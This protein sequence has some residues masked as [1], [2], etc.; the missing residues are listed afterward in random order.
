MNYAD[1]IIKSQFGI[2][3]LQL[4]LCQHSQKPLINNS[5]K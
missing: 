4:T 5:W 2:E 1:T 3:G